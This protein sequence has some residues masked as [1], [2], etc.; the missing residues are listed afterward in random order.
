M[1]EVLWFLGECWKDLGRPEQVQ[2]DNARELCGWGQSAY[3]LSRVIRLCLRH[4]VGPVFIPEGEARYVRIESSDRFAIR[5]IE[6]QPASDFPRATH[7]S[8]SKGL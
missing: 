8:T 3:A 5:R 4:G 2:L 6:V 1:D 7:P